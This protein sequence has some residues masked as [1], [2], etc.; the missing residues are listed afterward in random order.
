MVKFIIGTVRS[1]DM[2]LTPRAE[3]VRNFEHYM[4]G[5]T[6]EMIQKTRDEVLSTT[7]EDIRWTAEVIDAMLSDEYICVVG[8]EERI[9]ECEDMFGEIRALM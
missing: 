1:M 2:P 9:R 3:G 5:V 6:T 4:N 8:N 7:K